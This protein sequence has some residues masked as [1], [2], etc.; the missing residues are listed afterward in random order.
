MSKFRLLSCYKHTAKSFI[1]PTSYRC[2]A[3]TAS[4]KM[5]EPLK[6]GEV[7]KEQDPSVTKQYDSETSTG[8]ITSNL[9]AQ[10]QC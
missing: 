8:R 10:R 7:A 1:K 3:Q 9:Y 2:F 5:P 4:L 6:K